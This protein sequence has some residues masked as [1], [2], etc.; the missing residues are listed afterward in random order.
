MSGRLKRLDNQPSLRP[1]VI[2]DTW[3]IL[4]EKRIL[5]VAGLEVKKYCKTEQL[6][7]GLEA[8]M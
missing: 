1:V 6:F 8:D 3:K 5:K 4:F 7:G 2:G